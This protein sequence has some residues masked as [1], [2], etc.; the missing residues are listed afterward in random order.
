MTWIDIAL[1]GGLAVV[2]AAL[3]YI[4]FRTGYLPDVLQIAAALLGIAAL[5]LGSPI[6]VTWGPALF[7]AA[8]SAAVFYALRHVV[9]LWKQ[10]E[11][12]GLGDVKLIAVAGLWLGWWD[13][14]W[15][16]L[17]GGVVTLAEGVSKSRVA[18]G[19]SIWTSSLGANSDELLCPEGAERPR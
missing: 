7:G 15:V 11:A 12:M 2:L 17:T 4:D 14:P 9:S 3:A 10:R 16:M 19:R 8:G 6:G 13:I 5:A 18:D 1:S